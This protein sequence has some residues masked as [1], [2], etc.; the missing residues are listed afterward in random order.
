M[1]APAEQQPALLQYFA[2]EHL[3]ERLQQVSR[4]FHDLA[5]DLVA[6]LP[7]GPE[8]TVALRK[9]LEAKDAAVRSAVTPA[10]SSP[11]D[12][13]AAV[14]DRIDPCPACGAVVDSVELVNGRP[15]AQPCNHAVTV[16]RWPERVKLA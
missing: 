15:L 4:R 12:R 9:L 14:T 1:S 10:P 5:H 11:A 2:Y 8:L 7:L 3:P 6:D 13:L 16:T